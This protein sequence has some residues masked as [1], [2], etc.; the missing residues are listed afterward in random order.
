MEEACA[1]T[2]GWGQWNLVIRV[3]FPVAHRE[4]PCVLLL[5]RICPRSAAVVRPQKVRGSFTER[6]RDIEGRADLPGGI[7]SLR[8]DENGGMLR[9]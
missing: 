5:G 7:R 8:L 6:T 9:W 1:Q 2:R 4:I 3:A